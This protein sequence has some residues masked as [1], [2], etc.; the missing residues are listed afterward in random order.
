MSFLDG[1]A[2][3]GAL[4]SIFAMDVSAA[5]GRCASCG[6]TGPLGTAELYTHAPGL[7]MRCPGCETVLLRMVSAPGRSWVDLQG[8]AY[9]QL[10]TGGE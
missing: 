9:V 1:N 10:E 6:F 8:L 5:I 4:R 3:A 7:V 2:A